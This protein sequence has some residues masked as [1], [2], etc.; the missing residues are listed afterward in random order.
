MTQFAYEPDAWPALIERPERLAGRL[1]DALE[2]K[3]GGRLVSL[4]FC[5]GLGEWDGVIVYEAPDDITATA[6]LVATI[7]RSRHVRTSR[8]TKLLS[9]EEFAEALG[10]ASAVTYDGPPGAPAG[11]TR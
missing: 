6:I 2:N 1:V 8:T 10:K 5:F 7:A 9:T 3:L 11:A 4:Y